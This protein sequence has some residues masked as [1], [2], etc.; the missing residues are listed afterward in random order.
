MN[1]ILS[2]LFAKPKFS[3]LIQSA[4]GDVSLP[5]AP[6]FKVRQVTTRFVSR[7]HR[8]IL[9]DGNTIVDARTIMSTQLI[10]EGFCPD[11]DTLA[12][13]TAIAND[14]LSLYKILS[15]GL[16]FDNM[17]MGSENIEQIPRVLTASPVQL[18]FE[19]QLV[20]GVQ[21]IVF[22][23]AA[24]SSLIDRGFAALQEATTT[25]TAMATN[26]VSSLSK[27]L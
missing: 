9:E 12:Q 16:V 13:I 25:A 24:D 10:V 23:Q 7:A 27:I 2:S 4:G 1:S 19:E 6:N 18:H 21:P 3:I 26:A 20:V 17:K 5:V 11:I 8:H 15:K 14:R 22:A